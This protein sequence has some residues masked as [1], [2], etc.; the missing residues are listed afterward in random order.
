MCHLKNSMKHLLLLM[1]ALISCE[2]QA[3]FY[4]GDIYNKNRNQDMY[5]ESFNQYNFEEFLY[6]MQ[7]EE[8]AAGSDSIDLLRKKVLATPQELR[9]L[10][11]SEE[12][13]EE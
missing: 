10:G 1:L 9:K 11:V 12:I 7:G 13:I 2:I 8:Y 5:D 4:G 6:N 3:Q